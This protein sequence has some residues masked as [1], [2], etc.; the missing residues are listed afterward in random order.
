[1]GEP[2]LVAR[3]LEGVAGALSLGDRADEAARML[4]LAEATRA[5]VDVELPDAE[6]ADLLRV[7]ARL[8]ERLGD[9]RFD[10]EVAHGR[11]EYVS[12]GGRRAV[13]PR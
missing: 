2:R 1:M 13:T 3:T 9:A 4:G 6:R 5:G 10:E 7:T 12:A 8:R 11:E